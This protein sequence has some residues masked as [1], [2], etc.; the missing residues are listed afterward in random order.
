VCCFL[1]EGW[2]F[3]S[4]FG[5]QLRALYN[6]IFKVVSNEVDIESADFA[7]QHLEELLRG[8]STPQKE[9]KRDLEGVLDLNSLVDLAMKEER[10]VRRYSL[11][12]AAEKLDPHHLHCTAALIII[13]QGMKRVV[14]R[15]IG[16]IPRNDIH[17]PHNTNIHRHRS[18]M[19]IVDPCFAS[20]A[21][22]DAP[23]TLQVLQR[24]DHSSSLASK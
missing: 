12:E 14:Y 9:A 22:R 20:A 3:D 23:S 21:D 17:R 24:L 16:R 7:F 8:R 10:V 4:P 5:K 6:L 19:D 13:A 2:R 15:R 11:C 18:V 1:E